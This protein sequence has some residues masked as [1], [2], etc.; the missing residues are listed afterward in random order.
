MIIL[1]TVNRSLEVLLGGNATA[2]QLPVVVSYVDLTA[3]TFTPIANQTATNNTTA[4][5]AVAAPGASTQR[6]V[7]QLTVQNADTASAAVIVRYNDNST[8]RVLVRSTLAVNET[9]QYNDGLGWQILGIASSSSPLISG[10]IQ[11][12]HIAS[13]SVEGFFGTTRQVASG[14]VGVF[15]FGSGAVTAGNIGS[16]SVV[17]GN[18]AS[19]Q[20]GTMHIASG[21]VQSGNIAS[22][23][24]G[25][26]AIASGGVL[27]GNIASGSIGQFHHSSGCVVSGH[28]N[29]GNV[30]TYARNILE[31]TKL[32]GQA[33]SGVLAVTLGSGGQYVV[34]AER[35]S[36]L[37]MPALGVS[38]TN[39]VS[40]AAVTF[41]LEGFVPAA[42]SGTIASGAGGG[43]FVGSGGLIVNLSGF[44]GG[45]SSGPGV[46]SFSGSIIQG[47]GFAVSGGIYVL[48]DTAP[49]LAL[50]SGTYL[51][52]IWISGQAVQQFPV[53]G[54]GVNVF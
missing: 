30:I 9:L 21:G 39:A 11:S 45:G 8:T 28:I 47:V 33:I 25:S 54:L 7:K 20:V 48:I 35:Q 13:G 43:L 24:I 15:D 14:S 37:R 16:G 4:V 29:S 53:S 22:G 31:D 42:S 3:T 10:C 1:D 5:T 49:R 2:N 17:S 40:G 12:G 26:F 23:Q 19:G 38:V 36:G 52:S 27:S 50:Q 32:A 41:V 6:Q 51:R 46:G 18:I 44:M 34:P